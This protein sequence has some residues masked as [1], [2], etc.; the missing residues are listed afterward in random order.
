MAIISFIGAVHLAKLLKISVIIG[1][2][3]AFFSLNNSLVPLTGLLGIGAA[4]IISVGK[5]FLSILLI[6]GIFPLHHLAFHIPGLFGAYYWASS[7][8]AIRLL[9]PI[10]CMALFVLHPVGAHAWV[11]A[12]YWLIPIGLYFVP[13]KNLFVRALGSTFIAHAVGSVI[14]LYTV[15]MTAATWYALLPIVIIERMVFALGM[16]ILYHLYQYSMNR[17][18]LPLFA[19]M[20][21]LA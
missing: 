1:S 6:G 11:Y 8:I 21:H 14:W 16:V 15:P 2:Y 9:V 5:M 13:E 3:T 12:M 18:V 7:S 17:I 4:S 10:T 19:R 20:A